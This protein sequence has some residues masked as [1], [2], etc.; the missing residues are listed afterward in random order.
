MGEQGALKPSTGSSISTDSRH[1][2]PGATGQ[3]PS[4]KPSQTAPSGTDSP[5]TPLSQVSSTPVGNV[6]SE[7][8]NEHWATA[9][10][11]KKKSLLPTDTGLCLTQNRGGEDSHLKK[12]GLLGIS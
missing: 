10:S 12:A 2:Q 3:A 9:S 8:E 7:A 1:S 11:S 6:G 5:R 4:D